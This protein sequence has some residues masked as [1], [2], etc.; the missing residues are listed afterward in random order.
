MLRVRSCGSVK[1]I[2]I[3]RA[4]LMARLRQIASRVCADHREASSVRMFGSIARGDHVGT[5]DVD[6]LIVL[7]GA[8]SCDELEQTR[9]FYPY[10]DLPI[11]VDLLV[12]T[13]DQVAR[14]L[15]EDPALRRLWQES[16]VLCANV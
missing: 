1:I 6:V 13:E 5:S 16:I 2:S 11:G 10:F 9:L 4:E 14:R 7:R 12:C 8:E 15:Q 3:D